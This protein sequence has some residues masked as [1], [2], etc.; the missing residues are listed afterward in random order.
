M[1]IFNEVK[2]TV[3]KIFDTEDDLVFDDENEF[4]DNTSQNGFS[5]P[6]AFTKKTNNNNLQFQ[7]K[8]CGY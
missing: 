3:K 1:S 5:L 7:N 8:K 2:R 4:Q 6:K